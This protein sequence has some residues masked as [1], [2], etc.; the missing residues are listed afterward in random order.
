[1]LLTLT[2]RKIDQELRQER[3]NGSVM[4]FLHE[5]SIIRQSKKAK[6]DFIAR[7]SFTCGCLN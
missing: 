4:E 6:A 1:M 7:L 5:F 2:T 3:R